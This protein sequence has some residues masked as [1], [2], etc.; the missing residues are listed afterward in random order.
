MRFLQRAIDLL[1]QVGRGAAYNGAG[2]GGG[3]VP[4][5]QPLAQ[6]GGLAA[7]A[8]HV[9]GVRGAAD[10]EAV[11]EEDR[12]GDGAAQQLNTRNKL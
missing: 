7:C 6:H 4:H 5:Q 1:C 12:G 8:V 9:E 10:V 3:L 11:H 2:L